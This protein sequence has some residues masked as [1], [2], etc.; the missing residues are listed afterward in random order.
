MRADD[1]NYPCAAA[2]ELRTGSERH[3]ATVNDTPD[4]MRSAIYYPRTQVHS[5]GI[6]QSSLI[7][8]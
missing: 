3:M 6:M 5:Q 1:T 8:F 4:M 2:N 7:S